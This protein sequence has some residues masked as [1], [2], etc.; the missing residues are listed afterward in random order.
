[1]DT[2]TKY[3]YPDYSKWRNGIWGTARCEDP[4]LN[5]IF[6]EEVKRAK[7]T[8]LD[9]ELLTPEEPDRFQYKEQDL[10]R[11]GG[12][13]KEGYWIEV[14]ISPRGI[15]DHFSDKFDTLN[16]TVEDTLLRGY[17]D[18]EWHEIF[19]SVVHKKLT[20]IRWGV[21]DDAHRINSAI[22]L[23]YNSLILP[24]RSLLRKVLG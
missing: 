5:R 20:H 4:I 10:A 7:L 22:D 1:M 15:R 16:E 17:A 8:G 21:T 11:S 3:A 14:T 12:N 24:S 9:I 6:Q 23:V 19:S 2:E 18:L 13:W